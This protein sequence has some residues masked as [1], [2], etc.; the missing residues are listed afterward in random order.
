VTRWKLCK[1]TC[2]FKST[3]TLHLFVTVHGYSH[4]TTDCK[5]SMLFLLDQIPCRVDCQGIKELMLFRNA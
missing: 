3:C 5:L 1:E 2:T 4:N